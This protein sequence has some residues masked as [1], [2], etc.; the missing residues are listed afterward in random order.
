MPT[1]DPDATIAHLRK[2]LT[3]YDQGQ[4]TAAEVDSM[5]YTQQV[6]PVLEAVERGERY[7]TSS[8]CCCSAHPPDRSFTCRVTIHPHGHEITRID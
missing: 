4:L 1:F 3:K 8:S 5:L 6:V 7:L 2:L